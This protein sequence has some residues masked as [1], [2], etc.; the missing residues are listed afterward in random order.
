VKIAVLAPI[1]KARDSTATPVKI[2]DFPN[3]LNANL[4]SLH[5]LAIRIF[6]SSR[7]ASLPGEAGISSKD[8]L[9]DA[10]WLPNAQVLFTLPVLDALN[11]SLVGK[12]GRKD[13]RAFASTGMR[14]SMQG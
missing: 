1:P 5:R 13:V 4:A 10:K 6:P 11:S 9:A 3:I 12:L 2:G 8:Y 14:G 7:C